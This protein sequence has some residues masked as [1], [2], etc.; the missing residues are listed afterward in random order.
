MQ[1]HIAFL[2][3]INVGGHKKVPMAKLRET[4]S[5][6]GLHDV[7][8]YIQSGNIVFKSKIASVNELEQLIQKSIADGFGFT[9]PVLVKLTKEVASIL[10]DNPFIASKYLESN[11]VYFILLFNI[12]PEEQVLSFESMKYP[13]EE[14]KILNNC[15]YLLCKNGYG[16]ARLNN[17]SIERKL[18]VSATARNYRTMQKL[19]ELATNK[20]RS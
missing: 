11:Q 1:V 19:V 4:L 17:H 8:T 6:A 18:N 15:V 13:N 7:K 12:P 5:C 20:S 14:F 2:R 16:K 10:A 9:V 3:G